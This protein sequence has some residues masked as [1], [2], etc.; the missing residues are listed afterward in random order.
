MIHGM[1]TLSETIETR[2]T[3][4]MWTRLTR[5]GVWVTTLMIG[6]SVAM[7]NDAPLFFRPFEGVPIEREMPFKRIVP[8]ALIDASDDDLRQL[9]PGGGPNALPPLLPPRFEESETTPST[10]GMKA[11]HAFL[12]QFLDHDLDLT[13]ER[14]DEFLIPPFVRAY[15]PILGEFQNR[16]TPGLD[17]DPLYRIHP[18]DYPSDPDTIG[19]WDLSN[20][21]FR[22]LVAEDGSADFFRGPGGLAIIGD[23]RNDITG[24]IAQIHR[25]FMRLHNT[26]VDRIIARDEIDEDAVEFQSDQWWD[27]F[28]E[29]RNYVTAYH[30]GMV[31]GEIATQFT[32]RT[33]WDALADRDEPIGPLASP[34]GVLEFASAGFRLHTIVPATVQVGPDTFV[35]PLDGALRRGVSFDYLFG[36]DAPP[37]AKLDLAVVSPLRDIVGLFIP[38]NPLEITLDLMQVNILRQREVTL[39]SGEEYLA[40][41]LDEL[42]QPPATAVVRDKTVLTPRTARTF[43]DAVD[44]ADLLADLDAGDTDLH[45]YILAEAELNGGLLGPVGQDIFERTLI[46]L[47]AADDWSLIGANSDQFTP[48]QMAFFRDATFDRLLEEALKPED[49]NRDVIVNAADLAMILA[50]WGRRDPDLD[51]DEDGVVGAGDVMRVL[52]AWGP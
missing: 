22:I 44:D 45:A 31:M 39:P 1:A 4:R 43:L 2:M 47:L 16:R 18:L 46:G 3:R 14:N 11:G 27:I 6:A 52:E 48:E 25:A 51:L 24:A 35:S 26:Q 42:G 38:G 17:L 5:A 21:R 34:H 23:A 12:A 9:D 29:T 13:R 36:P 19:P 50:A 49:L 40:F 41:L 30:Q 32:G 15:L 37:A 28:N 7:A 8:E 20:L 33:L 10:S